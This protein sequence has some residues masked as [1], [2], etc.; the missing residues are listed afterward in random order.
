LFWNKVALHLV[1]QQP[2]QKVPPCIACWYKLGDLSTKEAFTP[3]QNSLKKFK[4]Y[5]CHTWQ[6]IKTH[7]T[8]INIMMHQTSLYLNYANKGRYRP[9]VLCTQVGT[10]P[11]STC[12]GTKQ[13]WKQ[14]SSLSLVLCKETNNTL[15]FCEKHCKK[16]TNSNVVKGK[17]LV[18]RREFSQCRY[19]HW[20]LKD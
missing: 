8:R 7:T 19:K 4:C 11:S 9:Q 18:E 6:K 14:H 5:T 1:T 13:A 17:K 12:I 20:M 15:Q 16:Q 2:C 3:T 10:S